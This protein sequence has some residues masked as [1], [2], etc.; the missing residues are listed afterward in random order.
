MELRTGYELAAALKAIPSTRD[1]HLIML[2]SAA[3][4]GDT[5]RAKEHG[6]SG[7]LTKPVK[8]DELLQCISMVL[9]LKTE[10]SLDDSIITRAAEEEAAC[11]DTLQLI[12]R[13]IKS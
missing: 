10:D 5:K 8:R 2:T 11:V 3:L 4:R 1:I 13:L 7:Y 9:G 6:F 12:L